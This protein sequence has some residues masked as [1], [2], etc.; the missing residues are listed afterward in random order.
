MIL[1]GFILDEFFKRFNQDT[2]F[3]NVVNILGAGF[4]IW[5]AYLLNSWPFL[6]LNSVWVA[7]AAFKLVRILSK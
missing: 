5:Y 3:Y 1:I 7:V 2:I 4:L 6:V